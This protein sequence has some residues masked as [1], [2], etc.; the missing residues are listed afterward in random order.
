MRRLSSEHP[1]G[2]D[3]SLRVSWLMFTG[4]AMVGGESQKEIE[5]Y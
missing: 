2:P 5:D 1:P 4:V 3:G